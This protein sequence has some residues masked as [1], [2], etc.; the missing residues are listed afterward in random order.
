MKRPPN[1]AR[2]SGSVVSFPAG[3]WAEPRPE[4]HFQYTLKQEMGLVAS[5]LVGFMGLK[6][7]S[8]PKWE[9]LTHRVPL[10]LAMNMIKVALSHFCCRITLQ[11]QMSRRLAMDNRQSDITA[12]LQFTLM[13]EVQYCS[14]QCL[15]VGRIRQPEQFSFDFSAEVF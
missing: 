8:K 11:C 5:I 12:V 10:L 1:P 13:P 6:C 15:T 4:K 3:S 7:L 2:V 14:R 9:L